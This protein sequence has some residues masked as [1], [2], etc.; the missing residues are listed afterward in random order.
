MADISM[1]D[2]PNC[3][4]ADMCFRHRATPDKYHQAYIVTDK[5]VDTDQDCDSFWYFSSE[6]ELKRLNI[7]WR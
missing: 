7:E 5:A 6:E 1:C 3:E 2:N 4:I